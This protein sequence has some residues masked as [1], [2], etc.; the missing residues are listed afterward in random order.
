MLAGGCEGDEGGNE[1]GIYIGGKHD[2]AVML[3]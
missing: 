3:L 1:F 2:M